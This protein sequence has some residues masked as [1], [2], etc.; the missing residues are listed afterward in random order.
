MHM[1]QVIA[2]GKPAAIE[3]DAFVRAS[4]FWR[5]GGDYRDY[6]PI[7]PRSNRTA[8]PSSGRSL[9]EEVETYRT[10]SCACAATAAMPATLPASTPTRPT[11]LA[12]PHDPHAP[13]GRPLAA[14]CS[15]AHQ[16]G[17]DGLLGSEPSAVQRRC[18]TS[19]AGGA[20]R[21]CTRDNYYLRAAAGTCMAAWLALDD[22]DEENGCMQIVAGSHSWP[23]LTVGA[24]LSQSFTDVTVPIPPDADVRPVVI[25]RPA[26]CSSTASRAWQLSNTSQSR[27]RRSLIGHYI[28][29]DAEQGALVPSG[30]TYGRQRR[31]VGG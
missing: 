22:C 29:G 24:D 30:P 21:R 2:D 11:R 20:A 15:T 31:R 12:Y 10:T 6:R 8:T 28:E 17:A 14:G 7:A 13:L 23:V 9:P 25:C 26:M 16:P 4:L 3:Q 18:F 1:G 5:I 19:P 27:F